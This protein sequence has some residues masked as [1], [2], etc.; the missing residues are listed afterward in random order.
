MKKAIRK[1]AA[2]LTVL[3][4]TTGMLT[5]CGGSSTTSQ[6]TAGG[7][8]A[9]K[10]T[11]AGT[12]AA[13]DAAS[14]GLAKEID[15]LNSKGEIQAALEEMAAAFEAKTGVKVNILACGAGEVPYTKI[16]SMYNSGT[17][18]T[19]AML[20]TT[21]IVALAEE[22][23]IDLSDQA[24]IAECE[25]N[26]TQV[27]GKVYSFPFCIEGRGIIYNK[28][29]IESTLGHAFDPDT[30]NSLESLSAL[31]AELRAAGMENP[32][33]ISKEDWSLGAHQLGMIYDTYDGTTAGAA[34]LISKLTDGSLKAIEYDRF[35]QFADTMDVLLQYNINGK[36]PLGALYE[37]D[38]I[39]LADGD[40]AFWLNGCWAWPNLAEAGAEASE[41]YG[42]LPWILGNDTTDFANTGIQAA[43]TKQVMIDKK[44]AT[45]EE[46]EA[47][48]AFLDWIVNDDEG[49]RMLVEV[50]AVIPAC[51]N[52]AYDPLDPLGNDIKQKITA[53]K[54]FSSSFIAPGDHWS[55]V[56]AEV[57]KYIAGKQTREQLA[58]NLDAYWQRQK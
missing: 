18:P 4:M 16:T 14:S 23:A 21:D 50:A 12:E 13:A 6:T 25:S 24:W 56:G 37:Q 8:A 31:L 17:A 29:A 48:R 40:A 38:P 53:G 26:I 35:N 11:G 51:K 55:A 3:G 42:F 20:D 5:G 41:E 28:Q 45:A 46:Q 43:A 19:M 32:V 52:N 15:F 58:E 34:E 27:N 44:Q 54:T 36:D 9:N 57:Q 47:A 39:Y 30:I 10:E 22:Y 1:A 2:V 7:A 33:V 49:Q